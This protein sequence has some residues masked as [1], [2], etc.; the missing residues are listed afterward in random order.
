MAIESG[1]FDSLGVRTIWIS[2]PNANPDHSEIGTGGFLY[3]G[4]HGYWP[5]DGQTTQKRFGDLSA[6][7]SMVKA[8]HARG[9]RVIAD[10]V[11]NHV[12]KEHPYYVD[13]PDWFNPFTINGQTCQCGT[14]PTDGCG[15]WN[16]N[17]P[18]GN[19][20]LLP[21][22]T[23]WFEPYLPDV[24]YENFSALT[25]M[26]DDA[27]YWAREADLDGFRVDAVKHFPTIVTRRLRSKLRDDFEH[28]QALFYLVGETFDGDR[29]LINS[30]IGNDQL[31]AQFD[32][33]LYFN[34]RD[35]LATYATSLRNLESAA[36]A[37]D[38]AFG[39]EPMSQF[40][41]NHDV[42]R[43][44][45]NAVASGAVGALTSDPQGQA[46]SAPPPVP[47]DDSAYQK[48]RLALTFV[49][50]QP[51][52]P[53]IYYGDEYGQ[54]GAGDPDNRRFM[55]WTGYSQW[56]SDTLT[57]AKKL[58]AARKELSALRRGDRKTLWIDDNL[59]VYS[60]TDGTNVAVVV[61]N[62]QWNPVTQS[63]PTTIANGTVLN[64][65]L[66]GGSVTVAGGNLP[67]N[68][69]AHSSMVLAP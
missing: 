17:Q 35:T 7:Q 47:A 42:A 18:N 53:L 28:A 8:A 11:L 36:T 39:S 20:G 67:L 55:K 3:T 68:V 19:H 6:L 50:T 65:R 48:L 37:S 44:L 63:V 66:Y 40:L 12:H 4:Y 5:T 10:T 15:D 62:R 43:F 46:W 45:S 64:D 13:H 21:R 24:D 51:G 1:Y 56:E 25:A 61:I 9:I 34:V 59:Y 2:P 38:A 33:P 57:I 23:C 31:N 26:V 60:R 49:A 22:Q 69:P 52:V 27:L 32:F 29:G 41:G 16:S 58:G 30:Y 54:P 14:G